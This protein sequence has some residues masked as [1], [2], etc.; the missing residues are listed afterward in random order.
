MVAPDIWLAANMRL[1]FQPQRGIDIGLAPNSIEELSEAGPT[2]DPSSR[3]IGM[4]V[5]LSIRGRYA[6]A[7]LTLGNRPKLVH[8]ASRSASRDAPRC[9]KSDVIR[10]NNLQQ[11]GV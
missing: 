1:H 3:S 5:L 11:S 2:P 9:F 8:L 7:R 4:D 6:D 10:L